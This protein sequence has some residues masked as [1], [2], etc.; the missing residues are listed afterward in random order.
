MT[1]TAVS[2]FPRMDRR[3]IDTIVD[4][5]SSTLGISLIFQSRRCLPKNL[6]ANDHRHR[7][8]NVLLV[9]GLGNHHDSNFTS[10]N[11]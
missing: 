5:P 2:K 1:D 9:Y 4:T 11:E 3:G 7:P 10:E 8:R 6:E